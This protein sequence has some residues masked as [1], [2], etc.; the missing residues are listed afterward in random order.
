MVI[1]RFWLTED[2]EYI[3]AAYEIEDIETALKDIDQ[4]AED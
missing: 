4:S 2:V 3:A 1:E